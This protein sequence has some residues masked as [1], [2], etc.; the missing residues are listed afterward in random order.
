MPSR[1]LNPS[2]SVS[3]ERTT[4]TTAPSLVDEGVG[5]DH[6]QAEQAS[7]EVGLD[8][9][10]CVHGSQAHD[11]ELSQSGGRRQ[12]H[13]AVETGRWHERETV[14][15]SPG[16]VVEPIAG[17]REGMTED[18]ETLHL[19][20][21]GLSCPFTW[22]NERHVSVEKV[23]DARCVTGVN[24]AVLGLSG[25]SE[26]E[27]LEEFK[28]SIGFVHRFILGRLSKRCGRKNVDEEESDEQERCS[29]AL[30]LHTLSKSGNLIKDWL[31]RQVSCPHGEGS[32][33]SVLGR[34]T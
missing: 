5:G 1:W 6:V 9:V 29:A 18:V 13:V 24:P 26:V 15:A 20:L 22:G 10:R 4:F 33:V 14:D 11:V 23:R 2:G 34:G 27:L 21:P 31:R 32:R 16:K 30:H 17:H 19:L 12:R 3:P 28:R 7:S 8:L 25:G